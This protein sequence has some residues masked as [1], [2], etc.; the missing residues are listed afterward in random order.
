V[1]AKCGQGHEV[2]RTLVGGRQHDI[3]RRAIVVRS[4]PIRS[5]HAPTIA[6]PEPGEAILGHWRDQVV[7]DT[8]LVLEER[9]GDH[10]A[11]RVASA[12]LRAGA[13]ATV[14]I[15]ARE[16]VDATRL[17]LSTEDVAI[18]HDRSAVAGAG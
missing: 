18:R 8:A 10:R 13:T 2:E 9:G 14:A 17:E 4:Q 12:V 7:A 5:G 3:G 1:L 6:G 15:E 11:D 16:R